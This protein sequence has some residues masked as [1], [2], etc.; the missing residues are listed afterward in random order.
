MDGM[1]VWRVKKKKT[2]RMRWRKGKRRA[3]NKRKAEENGNDEVY[4]QINK[5]FS[6]HPT[7]TAH[8]ESKDCNTSPG[9]IHAASLNLKYILISGRY[10][11]L[12]L[13]ASDAAGVK[14]SISKSENKVLCQKKGLEMS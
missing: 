11:V 10:L 13:L 8:S 6:F 5:V 9:V 1:D 12:F 4:F 2:G 7:K 14:T 3:G